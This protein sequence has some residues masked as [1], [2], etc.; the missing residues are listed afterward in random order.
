MVS[1]GMSRLAVLG[2]MTAEL[3]S[4]KTRT[5]NTSPSFNKKLGEADHVERFNVGAS[6]NASGSTGYLK[7]FDSEVT[8]FTTDSGGSMGISQSIAADLFASYSSPAFSITTSDRDWLVIN[9]H[10]FG[11]ASLET[12]I[13]VKL[14]LVELTLSLKILGYKFSPLD[15]QMALDIETG[16]DYCTSV[17]GF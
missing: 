17:G 16:E 2:I 8:L 7:S 1:S 12:S 5:H 9:P 4:A 15:F 13:T 11:E 3:A 10:L 6:T 14:I